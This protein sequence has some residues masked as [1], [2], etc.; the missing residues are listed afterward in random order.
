MKKVVVTMTLAI[1]LA[2][3]V[4]GLQ[5]SFTQASGA[6]ASEIRNESDYYTEEIPPPGAWS[7]V[8]APS[9]SDDKGI[10][11]V[12]SVT[13]SSK[14]GTVKKVSIRSRSNKPIIAVKLGWRLY[15]YNSPDKA[16]MSGESP[17]LGVAL[18]ENER[19]DVEFPVVS[20]TKISKSLV[21]DGR[22]NGDFKIEVGVINVLLGDGEEKT[23]ILSRSVST[24]AN[25]LSP[26]TAH[27]LKEAMVK[28]NSYTSVVTLEACQNQ[29]CKWNGSCFQ[30]QAL[31]EVTCEPK[32]DC[33]ECK[34]T[35]CNNEGNLTRL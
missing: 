18:N 24:L 17:F 11:E 12:Y 6:S 5:V 2:L 33:S 1:S 25:F 27:S 4:I 35:Q 7:L 19:R 31:A 3:V 16:L 23:S 30:C 20:F 32:P 29:E 21:K 14:G 28:V 22:L 34:E 15:Y 13:S 9:L 10:A 26:S 8:C